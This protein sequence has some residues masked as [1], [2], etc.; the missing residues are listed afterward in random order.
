MSPP[1]HEP[2][3]R[4]APVHEAPPSTRPPPN[5]PVSDSLRCPR[6]G[7][8][9]PADAKFCRK[10]GT[11][12]NG[13][14]ATAVS[15]PAPVERAPVSRPVPTTPS[16]QPPQAH[17]PE[18]T[19]QRPSRTLVYVGSVAAVL[20]LV[21]VGAVLYWKGYV[22]NRQGSVAESLS[23]E[24][25]A[26]D[27]KGVTV[28]I[29]KQWVATV[30]GSVVGNEARDS[31]LTLVRAGD[32]VSDVVDR[33]DVKASSSEL[34][35]MVAKTLTDQGFGTIQPMVGPDYRATL[36][37]MI[38]SQKQKDQAVASV[39]AV[40]GIVDIVDQIQRSRTWNQSELN[41]ALI[42]QGLSRVSAT[43][44]D[45]TTVELDGVIEGSEDRPRLAQL[46]ADTVGPV[47]V[48]MNVRIEPRPV[49][50][51]PARAATAPV[52]GPTPA[53]PLAQPQIA[54]IRG[55]WA[56]NVFVL[57]LGYNAN[58][59]LT[60]GQV[61]QVVGTTTYGTKKSV[62]CAGQVVLTDVTPDTVVL[63]EEITQVGVLCPGGG[64]IKMHM[65]G[66]NSAHV[67]WYR[68]K[69]PDK[70]SVKG[71]FTRQ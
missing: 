24:A 5:P 16:P 37:G 28:T 14:V 57:I 15:A 17:V 58:L 10:D 56:G 30:T 51:T 18:R 50:P 11:P 38:D 4:S 64:T 48:Q 19:R 59:R 1:S 9:N 36:S 47:S 39:R 41:Q 3:A 46:V 31:V 8:V 7:T 66:S 45:D 60:D 71:D 63:T 29:D 12:L 44:L 40:P 53:T 6:C 55:V 26:Q 70:V 22:G 43:Y 34:Q 21:G 2:Q 61:G 52:A 27:F 49:A 13:T 62:I 65:Q 35:Y 25:A 23:A 54:H 68:K 42:R 67:E 69:T 32:G 33:L 20:L